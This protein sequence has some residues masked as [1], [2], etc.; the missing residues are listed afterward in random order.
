MNPDED[1][2][3]LDPIWAALAVAYGVGTVFRS[4][5][6]SDVKRALRGMDQYQALVAAPL[7]AEYYAAG[8]GE[9]SDNDR[10]VGHPFGAPM[11]T[12]T[13]LEDF[14]IRK[15]RIERTTG[16]IGPAEEGVGEGQADDGGA[17]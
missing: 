3:A 12:R 8:S 11:N 2:V 14:L 15:G 9:E 7:V 1:D 13:N 4:T 10:P 16:S 6:I 5:W 17:E